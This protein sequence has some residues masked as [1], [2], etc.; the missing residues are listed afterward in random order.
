MWIGSFDGEVSKRELGLR[1]VCLFSALMFSAPSFATSVVDMSD[2]VVDESKTLLHKFA[3]WYAGATSDALFHIGDTAVSL[4]DLIWVTAVMFLAVI[5]SSVIQRFLNRLPTKHASFS[6]SGMFTL[7]RLIHYVIL[8]VAILISFGLLGID[9]TKLA[10]VA[11]A[12]S[13]GIGFGL[14]SIFNNFIS[15]LILLFERPMRVGDLIELDSGTRGRVKSI[16]VR[17]TQITTWDNIDIMVPNSE[18]I[19]GRVVNYTLSDDSRRLHIPFGVAYGTDKDLVKKAGIEASLEI[20]NTLNH[21][22]Y[23]PD[24]WLVNF[25]DS[26]LDFELV[27]WVKGN[28]LP[29]DKHPIGMYLWEIETKLAEY[30][31]EIPFPQRD[32]RFRSVDEEVGKLFSEQ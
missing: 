19:S 9:F 3:E 29:V 1:V 10:I 6:A 13:V 21:G 16:N 22:E 23:K 12:L 7:G 24:V 20:S 26:S 2:A 4:M 11:G 27:V 8:V 28:Q 18:F 30:G 31:I 5:V 25:G 14:Q 17:S 32:V 15:G